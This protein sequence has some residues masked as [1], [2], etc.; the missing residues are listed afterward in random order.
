MFLF[1]IETMST[2]QI[3]PDL[4]PDQSQNGDLHAISGIA[5]PIAKTIKINII[6]DRMYSKTGSRKL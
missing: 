1:I 3:L 6:E 2:S 5:V 4:Q